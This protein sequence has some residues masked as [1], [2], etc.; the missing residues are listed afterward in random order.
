MVMTFVEVAGLVIVMIIGVIYVAQGN[1]DFGTLTEFDAG[2]KGP[3]Y[4]D[5]RRRRARL[6]RHDRL[7]ER[8]QRGRGDD[9]PVQELPARTHRRHGRGRRHLRAGGDDRRRS[10]SRSTS[11]RRPTPPCS[12]S[13]RPD[14]LPISVG[15]MT[16]VFAFIAMTAITNTTLVAVVTQSRILYGMA[17]RT[18]C[19]APSPRSTRSGAAPSFGADLL[20]RRGLWPADHRHVLNES[21]FGIDIV[22]PTRD[23]DR[24]AAAVHL[25]DGHRLRFKLRGPGRGT[26]ETYRASRRCWASVWSATALLLGLRH[27]RRPGVADLVRRPD[28]ARVRALPHRVLPR[29]AE[30]PVRHRPRR[31]HPRKGRL[32]CTSSSPPTARSSPWTRAAAEVPS[33]T[34]RRSPPSRSSRSSGPWPRWRSPTTSRGSRSAADPTRRRSAPP[35]RARWPRSPRSSTAGA[36]RSTSGSAAGRR[37]TRSSRPPQLDAG[38]VVVAAG[39]RGLSDTVLMGSTAQ[40]VQHYAPCPVLVVR[41]APRKKKR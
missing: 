29:L 16:I 8:R 39:G 33:P 35:P 18:S 5:H 28:R 19:P 6:L 2:A 31:V 24:R 20:G 27:L 3:I 26:S 38:L 15:V 13:S 22:G 4:R 30:P 17:R 41:P 34:R 25:R 11:S 10:S 37:P 1:A 14:I 21:A 7:R 40:R 32:R 9:Q 12:R 36:R 23:R